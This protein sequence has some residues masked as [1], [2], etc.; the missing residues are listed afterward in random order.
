M[1]RGL[2]AR[3]AS[4]PL[5]TVAPNAITA[6]ALCLGLTGIRFAFSEKWEAALIAILVAG[7]LDGLDGRVAR[8]L[9]AQSR[10][11]EQLDSLS[12]CIAFGVAPT[13][14]LY[15]WS[16]QMW[17][18]FGW[19]CALAIALSCALRLARFNAR[20][21]AEEQPHKSAGF[22]T[23]VPAPAGAGL[24]FLPIYSW[25]V[26]GWD[27]LREP[28]VVAAW[29]VGVALLMISSIATFSWSSLRLRRTIRLEAIFALGILAV[30]LFTATWPTL[31]AVCLVYLIL[32]PFSIRSYARVRRPRAAA[33]SS[34]DQEWE[35]A[36]ASMRASEPLE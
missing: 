5:R 24:A 36:P 20:I 16:L 15:L 18:R 10:F 6:M 12:D 33:G 17:P 23:G 1:G 28:L 25:F 30:A 32:I 14:V 22:M 11:G 3:R 29:A 2:K 21:D 26:T 27:W 13:F 35:S 8:L 19:I 9:R 34:V 4:I 7:V 31:V